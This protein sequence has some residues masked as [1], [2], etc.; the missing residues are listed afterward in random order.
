MRIPLLLSLGLLL[1]L[2]ACEATLVVDSKEDTA[3]GQDPPAEDSGDIDT[4]ER[5]PDIELSTTALDFGI[6]KLGE[7]LTLPVTVSNLGS[8]DLT[9]TL[10]LQ[11]AEPSFQLDTATLSVP[12]GASVEV[13]IR[14]LPTVETNVGGELHAVSNDPDEP[15]VAL[16]LSGAAG[17]DGDGDGWVSGSDC[18]DG[19]ASVHPEAE[20]RCNGVDEDCDGEIDD[21]PVDGDVWYADADA[22]GYGDPA[23]TVR[24]CEQ[25]EGYLADASDCNDTDATV[26]PAGIEVCNAVDDDCDGTVD[27]EAMDPLVWYADTDSDGYGDPDN[28]AWAC[29]APVGYTADAAD[30]DDT[31][32]LV[33][34]AGVEVCNAVD[35]DCNGLV[36]DDPTDA[37]AWYADSDGDG[38]GDASNV[39]TGCEAPDGYVADD[40]DCDDADAQVN[41]AAA[42]LCN[43][44]D[45]DC[46]GA[47]DDNPTDELVW[48]ADADG[49]G[50]GDPAT[51]TASCEA[52]A[53][54]LADASDCDD[55]NAAVSPAATE[56]CNGVDDDCD[57][58]VDDDAT[59]ATT[60][61]TDADGD[62]YGDLASPVLSC[63]AA[64]GIVADATDCDDTDAAVNP[65]G[66][67]LCNGVDE[68]CD[69]LVDN[70]AIDPLTWYAD[71]DGDAYGDAASTT[72]SCDAPIG[73]VADA[74]D[75]D[76][77]ASGVNPGADELCNGVDDDCDTMVDNDAIDATVWYRDTDTDTY[78]DPSVSTSSCDQPAG[79]VADDTDCDDTN[80]AVNPGAAEVAYNQIDDNCDGLQDEMVANDESGWTILGT[81]ASHTIGNTGLWTLDDL[82]GDGDDE[83]AIAATADDSRATNAGA[84]AF[85]DDGVSGTG[86]SYTAAYL[87]VGGE[88]SSDAFGQAVVSLD[89][90]DG[91]GHGELAASA[92][93]SNRG[94][95]DA[96]AV[97]IFDLYS[98]S[99]Y[100]GSQNVNSIREGRIS[101]DSE[102]LWLGYSLA[103]ADFDSDGDLDLA[104]GA[105][106][107]SDRRGRVYGFLASSGYASSSLDADDADMRPRGPSRSD[108]LG[109][110][111]VGGDFNG[112]GE[113]DLVACASGY[114]SGGATSIGSCYFLTGSDYLSSDEDDIDDWD[115]ANFT[116]TVTSDSLGSG[117]LTVTA[118]DLDA[119]GTDDLILGM[120]GYDGGSSGSG[121]VLVQYGGAWAGTYTIATV[122][123]V[124]LGDGALGTSVCAPGDVDGDGQADLL[125]GAP[126]AGLGGVVYLASGDPSGSV[127]L[128]DGQLA[129]WSAQASGDAL[130]AA[131]AGV[132]DLDNDGTPDLAAAATGFDPSSALTGAGKVYVLPGY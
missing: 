94:D 108:A 29:S 1:P 32:A 89:D 70:D 39:S 23:A 48:Y 68:D 106:G 85:H 104:A 19:D 43:G 49:D 105:P 88:S 7:E 132:R 97:Y 11:D 44:L 90:V 12:P 128:P 52:P 92:Y 73:Y 125:L 98:S 79:Y 117:P 53:G 55:G 123:A 10:T 124:L 77:A 22:D 4:A 84:L 42:E 130:G 121:A 67:E 65:V 30:C 72:T 18:N 111:M 114:D 113:G 71:T 86:V 63:D 15:D 26:N 74:T 51:T 129:S 40:T 27:E 54:Y 14:F 93:L 112:D 21:D 102:D 101:G 115:T 96:G 61:Y 35:D 25:P 99:A 8:S 60:W 5:N 6:L 107:A 66:V 62:G 78:G 116:G 87:L 28:V 16:T 57:G 80:A 109:T 122:D 46:N 82:N 9:G 131:V 3:V 17:V 34:P 103:T 47:V 100:T 38:Y 45:D 24:A 33:S 37:L 36:D 110:A 41:P 119:D 20:E 95:D 75:C 50:Y 31:D 56:L 81:S 120:A 118:G 126:T 58:L 64:A 69:G 13:H 127:T 76:D 91:D 83:L 2:S 59:D